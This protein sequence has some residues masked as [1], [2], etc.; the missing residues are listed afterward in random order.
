MTG[1]KR[2]L[3][4]VLVISVVFPAAFIF[5]QYSQLLI[6]GSTTCISSFLEPGAAELEKD[7]GIMLK[8]VGT[9]TGQGLF[10]L[11]QGMVEVSAASEP[12]DEAIKSAKKFAA[13][14]KMD[15][16]A[17]PD[18]L[19][20]H[21]I[22]DDEIIVIVHRENPVTSLT[23]KQL[24]G[25]HTGAIKNW[26]EVG[27]LDMPVKIVTS[28]SGSATRQFFQKTVMEG[29]PYDPSAVTVNPTAREIEMVSRDLGAIG[30]VSM[31]FYV[32]FPQNTKVLHTERI[33]RPLGLITRGKPS[34][35]VHKVISFFTKG[36][37]RKYT[38]RPEGR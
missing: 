17:I 1:H 34:E 15:T 32:K 28:H 30:A 23:W 21:K 19:E 26:K 24:K 10:A 35:K 36:N 37:G 13:T 31:M 6:Y 20:F 18:N 12:L 27:G 29:A 8:T 11:I 7:T 14:K 4:A 16:L 33:V 9:G 38:Q 22:M 25:L 3:A 2:L 5:A